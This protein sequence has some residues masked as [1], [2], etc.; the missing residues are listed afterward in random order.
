MLEPR[1]YLVLPSIALL[2][3]V[4]YYFLPSQKDSAVGSSV[5]DCIVNTPAPPDGP[6]VSAS[7]P[8]F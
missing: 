5:T 6:P 4:I 2:L 1:G 8:G 3:I 7:C